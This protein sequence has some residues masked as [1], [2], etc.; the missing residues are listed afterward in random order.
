MPVAKKCSESIFSE[1][2]YEILIER[3]RRTNTCWGSMF[4]SLGLMMDIFSII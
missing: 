3:S 4:P 2:C 1:K